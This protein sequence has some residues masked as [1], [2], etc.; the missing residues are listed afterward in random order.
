MRQ[1]RFG[2]VERKRDVQWRAGQQ[3]QRFHVREILYPVRKLDR[4]L[5]P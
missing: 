2:K 3:W 4:V 1:L 5:Q